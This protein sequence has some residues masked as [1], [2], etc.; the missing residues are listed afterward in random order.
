MATQT[1]PSS[2]KSEPRD[3]SSSLASKVKIDPSS[4]DK[5]KI[6]SSSRPILS[7]TKPRSSVSTVTAKSE[8]SI[9]KKLFL[10][11]DRAFLIWVFYFGKRF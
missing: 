3:G 6:A 11:F 7:D 5:K 2:L 8:V 9:G 4:K 1:K 10:S